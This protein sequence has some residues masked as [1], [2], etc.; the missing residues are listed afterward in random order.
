MQIKA[1]ETLANLVESSQ[2][3]RK[4]HWKIYQN[5]LKKARKENEL[6]KEQIKILSMV[7]KIF[8]EHWKVV[9]IPIRIGTTVLLVISL[10]IELLYIGTII[11]ALP[12]LNAINNQENRLIFGLV[13]YIMASGIVY[14]TSHALL[15]YLIG[16]PLGIKFQS[17]FIFRAGF[18]RVYLFKKVP[19]FNW[20]SKLPIWLGI[21]YDLATFL[22]ANKWKRTMMLISAPIISNFLFIFNYL[23][24]ITFKPWNTLPIFILLIILLFYVGSLALSY[25]R[26]GDL[27]KARQDY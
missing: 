18:R 21:K 27:W 8:F 12:I 10:L 13:T 17:Y 4:K 19:P 24:L 2:L 26:Y 15:H 23:I 3:N 9:K 11:G 5:A 25:F 16:R 22:R 6:T 1:I 14:Y 20:F 7:D